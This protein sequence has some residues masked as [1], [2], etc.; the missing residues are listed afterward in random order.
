M[1]QGEHVCRV[2]EAGQAGVPSDS[3]HLHHSR[4]RDLRRFRAYLCA[5]GVFQFA[6]EQYVYST[7][8]S[9]IGNR[10]YSY[11]DCV[12]AFYENSK[13]C[14]KFY[15]NNEI[16]FFSKCYISSQSHLKEI[17]DDEKREVKQ[18]RK[19]KGTKKQFRRMGLSPQTKIAGYVTVTAL[20]PQQSMYRKWPKPAV[21]YI[22]TQTCY[23]QAAPST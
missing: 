3:P 20:Q 19:G 14:V 8:L 4:R 22:A 9:S 1:Q 21:A 11:P 2:A 23:L 15:E 13:F 7:P 17:G 5:N 10:N 12:T 16:Y 6:R 18:G